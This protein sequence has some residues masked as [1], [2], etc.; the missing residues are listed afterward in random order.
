MNITWR[1]SKKQHLLTRD[2]APSPS[3]QRCCEKASLPFGSK[4]SLQMGQGFEFAF[5]FSVKGV[6][7]HPRAYRQMGPN[8][9]LS[10][11]FQ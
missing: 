11:R 3:C 5:S 1:Y 2:E 9:P 7:P 4:K 8:R 6:Y 10:H